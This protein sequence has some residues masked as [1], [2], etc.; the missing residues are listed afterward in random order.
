MF[1]A[2]SDWLLNQWISCTIHWFTSSSSERATPNSGKLQAKCFPGVLPWTN[3]EI[4]QLIKQAAPEIHKEGDEVWFGGL[5][6]KALSFWLEFINKTSEKV[7]VYT[8]KLSLSLALLYLADLFINK[9]KTKF[10]NLFYRMIFNTK[11]IHNKQKPSKVLFVGKKKRR[12]RLFSHC[13]PKLWSLATVNELKI[14]IFVLNYLT[15]LV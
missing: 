7:F 3:K 8:C 1:F 2:R 5:T 13:A 15:V 11:R 14:I 9:L 6:G 12:P 4:S 10:N